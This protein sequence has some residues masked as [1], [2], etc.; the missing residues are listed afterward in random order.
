MCHRNLRIVSW[1]VNR[2]AAG[3]SGWWRGSTPTSPTCC[4]CRDEVHRRAVRTTSSAAC[5][6]R[7]ATRLLTTGATIGTV[8]RS[9]VASGWATCSAAS[10][11]EPPT[12]RRGGARDQRGVRWGTCLV[13]LQRPMGRGLDDPH[14]LYKLVWFE[15]LASIAATGP[16]FVAGDFK[17]RAHRSRHLRPGPL[18]APHPRQARP[19]GRASQPSSTSGWSTSPTLACRGRGL[20]VVELPARPVRTEPRPAHRSGAVPRDADLAARTG[21][22]WM[23]HD[24]RAGTKASDHAPMVV[25][26]DG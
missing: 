20:H 19:N 4:C 25:D 12:V 23:D 24:E 10:G 17:R 5:T 2:S 13:R 22:V 1:N 3:T 26:L 14:Y 9:S 15:R 11:G 6:G 7:W 21:R 18:A 16:T 8:S